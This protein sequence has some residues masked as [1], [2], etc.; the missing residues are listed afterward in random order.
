MDQPIKNNKP[1]TIGEDFRAAR[2]AKG[3][4]TSQAAAATRIKVQLIEDME[5]SDFSQMAAPAYIKGFIRIYAEYLGLKS[6]PLVKKYNDLN[7]PPEEPIAEKQE[8][9]FRPTD[10]RQ[11]LAASS[12]E[13]TAKP[14]APASSASKPSL[15]PSGPLIE[16][17][18][19]D[20]S[21]RDFR[22]FAWL[23]LGLLGLVLCVSIF[24][25]CRSDSEG[26]A[27]ARLENIV[28]RVEEAKPDEVLPVIPADQEGLLDLPDLHIDD[29]REQRNDVR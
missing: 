16:K 28:E 6:E 3:V 1:T 21:S 24:K 14:A 5:N 19:N 17:R 25:G 10:L 18:S 13:T 22:P 15:E 26:D 4:S 9:A 11:A 23:V 7:K 12:A 20:G 2:D 8:P 29:L 27:D